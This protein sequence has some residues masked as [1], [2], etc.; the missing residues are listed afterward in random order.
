MFLPGLCFSSFCFNFFPALQEE[1][2]CHHHHSPLQNLH[3]PRL[4]DGGLHQAWPQESGPMEL[5]WHW[6]RGCVF[7]GW[8]ISI[9][10]LQQ[11]LS[12]CSSSL[13][14]SQIH[15]SSGASW[16]VCLYFIFVWEGSSLLEYCFERLFKSP[17]PFPLPPL[18]AGSKA[19]WAAVAILYASGCHREP[20]DSS[21]LPHS[22]SGV[23][24][25]SHLLTVFS[26]AT[27]DW[28]NSSEALGPPLPALG[29]LP[30]P[31]K[32]LSGPTHS[33]V[34]SCHSLWPKL[35]YSLWPEIIRTDHADV[36]MTFS[37]QKPLRLGPKA[38][39]WKVF[40]II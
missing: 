12:L 21:P 25:Q 15:T 31:P 27:G 22:A 18:L 24:L 35:G 33:L 6:R 4:L 38:K 37:S 3:L 36:I 28:R 20:A 29:S 40:F 5:L 23:P 7:S 17:S 16:V 30:Q 8:P 10:T 32:A 19:G 9:F 14:K 11:Q 26:T 34:F 1:L 39:T 2:Q 13:L